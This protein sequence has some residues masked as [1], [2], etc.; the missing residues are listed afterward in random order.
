MRRVAPKSYPAKGEILLDGVGH[1][2]IGTEPTAF[3]EALYLAFFVNA[4]Y[5]AAEDRE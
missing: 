5:I 4:V 2:G 1:P 3:E